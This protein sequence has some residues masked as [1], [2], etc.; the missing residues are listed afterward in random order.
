ME[1][2]TIYQSAFQEPVRKCTVASMRGEGTVILR[3][4][5]MGPLDFSELGEWKYQTRRQTLEGLPEQL[6]Q[7]SLSINSQSMGR[8]QKS[9]QVTVLLGQPT[10]MFPTQRD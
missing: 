4:R 3:W 6:G 7:L 2:D 10:F 1:E 5:L 9:R 8:H